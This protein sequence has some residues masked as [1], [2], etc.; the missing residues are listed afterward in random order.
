[1]S[2][3]TR[4]DSKYSMSKHLPIYQHKSKLVE[5]VRESTFLLVTGETGSGKTT[6]LPQYLHQAGKLSLRHRE[7]GHVF[8]S[9]PI[10]LGSFL[11]QLPSPFSLQ[12]SVKMERSPSPSPAEWLPSQWRREC[13]R[14]CSAL[15]VEKL[16]TRCASMTAHHRWEAK[17]KFPCIKPSL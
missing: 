16:A 14:R 5:A 7:T 9:G 8:S 12:V 4:W 2:K 1:M 15:W 10:E 3:S 11:C 17:K 6:Q 13:L